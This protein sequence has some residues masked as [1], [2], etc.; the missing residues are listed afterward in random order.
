MSAIACANCFNRFPKNT[1]HDCAELHKNFHIF[2]QFNCYIA[3]HGRRKGGRGRQGLPL[4]VENFNKKVVFLGS[5]GKKQI[6]PLP[7][8]L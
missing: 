7:A 2:E 3:G 4:Y 1:L 5:S 8:L 6:S